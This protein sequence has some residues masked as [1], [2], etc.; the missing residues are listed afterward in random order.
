MK[1]IILSKLDNG[2]VR[3]ESAIGNGIGVWKGESPFST[4]SYDIE[5]DIDDYFE[6][7]VNITSINKTECHINF[8]DNKTTFKA[9]VISY[10]DDGVLSISLNDDVIFIEVST[11]QLTDGYVSFFTTPDKVKLY[12]IE[13]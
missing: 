1:N 9:K 8:I 7:G 6:W 5:L 4:F 2:F 13:L 11:T 10:E 3:F 12:P